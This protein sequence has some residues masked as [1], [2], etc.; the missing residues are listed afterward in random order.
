MLKKSLVALLASVLLSPFLAVAEKYPAQASLEER[1]A[2]QFRI[3]EITYSPDGKRAAFSVRE[4]GDTLPLRNSIWLFESGAPKTRRLTKVGGNESMPRWSP[5]G[6]R[7]AFLEK[8][9]AGEARI[10]VVDATGAKGKPVAISMKGVEE[11]AWLGD[12]SGVVAMTEAEDGGE[13]IEPDMV[14][15]SRHYKRKEIRVFDLKTGAAK[16]LTQAPWTVGQFAPMPRSKDVVVSAED[17]LRPEGV[18]RRLFVVDG[19]TGSMREFGR[20]DG[21]E[22]EKLK[23]SPDG[24]NLAYIGSADGPTMFDIYVQPI[25][26]GTAKNVTGPASAGINRKVSDYDWTGNASLAI[27]VEDGFG[28]KMYGVNLDG[29]KRLLKTFD[30]SSVTD[31][32]VSRNQDLL[33]AKG[34]STAPGEVW[35]SEGGSERQVSALHHDFPKLV[36]GRLIDY[37]SWDGTRIQAK[38]FQPATGKAPW[39]TVVLIHGGPAGRWSHWISD[40]AQVLV[41]N[42]FVVIAPNIRGSTGYSQAF[43]TGNRADWGG[44]DFKDAMSGLDWL[45]GEGIS[46]SERL[47]I[48]GWS[49]GGYMGAWA[50]TQT[51]RF[52]ASVAGAGMIDLNLQWGAGMAEVVP[53]DSWYNGQPWDEPENFIRMSPI[54]YVEAVKTPTMLIVGEADKIDPPIQNWMFY[55]ALRMNDVPTELI[56]Y[57]REPHGLSERPHKVD[58][59]RRMVGWMK[60]YLLEQGDR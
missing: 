21:A 6:S 54:T 27:A 4:P 47:G 36:E 30:E 2:N 50:V 48:A 56:I 10:R 59:A 44:G 25:T 28:S 31:F 49:Y 35:V 8:G 55:R 52:K 3:E 40:W 12:N 39:P 37:P 51:N 15:G 38:L 22:Y 16:T 46:D 14:I 23:M 57:P 41:A 43:M 17:V 18:V 7:L 1:L 19:A 53:Y 9:N 34:S 32:A 60:K 26:G 58:A 20:I 11:L 13:S 29:S 5:D 33:Y 45:I 42:G 24:R